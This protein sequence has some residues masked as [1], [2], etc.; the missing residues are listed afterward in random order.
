MASHL[1]GGEAHVE[2]RVQ[3][4][5]LL[6]PPRTGPRR[7]VFVAGVEV[8]LG[9]WKACPVRGGM[10]LRDLRVR[11]APLPPIYAQVVLCQRG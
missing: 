3:V 9:I 2:R 11:L 8:A 10:Y 4:Q 5:A 6:L 1:V 7:Q